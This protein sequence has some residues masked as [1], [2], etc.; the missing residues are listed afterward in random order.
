MAY[1]RLIGAGPTYG[2]HSNLEDGG[3]LTCLWHSCT[4]R[5][6]GFS[7]EALYSFQLECRVQPIVLEVGPAPIRHIER[8][9]PFEHHLHATLSLYKILVKASFQKCNNCKIAVHTF[10]TI[11]RTSEFLQ[12]IVAVQSSSNTSESNDVD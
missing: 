10:P 5:R 9:Y 2:T 6:D 4:E 8:V 7:Q 3:P 12:C 1:P 11:E